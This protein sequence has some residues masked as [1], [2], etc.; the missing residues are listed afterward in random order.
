MRPVVVIAGGG[1]AGLSCAHELAS[2]CDVTIVE[3]NNICGGQSRSEYH[4]G[5]HVC[6]SW[7]IFTTGYRNLLHIFKQI[8]N[9]NGG[10][11]FDNMVRT[12]R[13]H[14]G[15]GGQTDQHIKLAGH[16]MFQRAR[17][18]SDSDVLHFKTKMYT[19]LSMCSARINEL[20]HTPFHVYMNP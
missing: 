8:P 3:R 1:I 7:R 16:S 14:T 13:Y 5:A 17:G 2:E 10:T 19:L 9:N 4:H 12:T 11:L 6:Y 20:E 18:M 15:T